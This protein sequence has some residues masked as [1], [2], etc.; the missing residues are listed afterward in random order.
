MSNLY[1]N[2]AKG[3]MVRTK[4]ANKNAK[5]YVT[6]TENYLKSFIG[7]NMFSE[8]KGYTYAIYS[9]GEHFPMYV[10]DQVSNMWIGN[11]DKYSPSTSRQQSQTRPYKVDKW[12]D[13]ESLKSIVRDGILGYCI[14]Q[15]SNS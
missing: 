14:N 12:V 9:Y 7:S 2:E 1:V 4:I 15:A 11:L 5:E 8:W 13:T 6:M 3:K 10:Y